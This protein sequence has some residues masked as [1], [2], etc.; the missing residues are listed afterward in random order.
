MPHMEGFQVLDTLAP[1]ITA[2]GCLPILVVSA[3]MTPE[4]KARALSQAAKDFLHKPFDLV[5]VL[6]RIRNLLETRHLY[7]ELQRQN[8]I[9]EARVRERTKELEEAQ[10]EVIDRLARAAEYRD[11][12]TGQHTR[13]VGELRSEEHT[14]EL[15]SR[16][17]LVC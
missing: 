13:R 3:D 4:T 12:S 1:I 15:Q 8:E 17:H 6:L 9:L 7:L 11:H 14:S 16:G 2:A 5:E 10:I